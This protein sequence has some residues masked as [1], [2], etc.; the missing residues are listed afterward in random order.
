MQVN[1]DQGLTAYSRHKLSVF[2]EKVILVYNTKL[3]RAQ[4]IEV[5]PNPV[6]SELL[7]SSEL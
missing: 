4:G 5:C 2:D 3:L 1:G 6:S 7:R